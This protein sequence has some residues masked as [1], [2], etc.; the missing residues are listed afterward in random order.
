MGAKPTPETLWTLKYTSDWQY[1]EPCY[2]ILTVVCNTQNYWV[3]ALFPSSGILETIKH[4]VSET[5]SVS[6]LGWEGRKTPTQLG[7]LEGAN[8]NHWTTPVRVSQS[9]S[10]F[11]LAVYRQSVRLGDKPRETH[12][13]SFYFLTKHLWL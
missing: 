12:D 3:F 5:G 9:Q 8:L 11:R 4:D 7:P 2:S 10:Y 6:V 1:S 13:Q